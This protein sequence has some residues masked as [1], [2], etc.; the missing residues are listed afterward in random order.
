M[1]VGDNEATACAGDGHIELAGLFLPF[2]I[3]VGV[4]AGIFAVDCIVDDDGVE[5]QSLGLMDGGDEHAL[6]HA[7]RA[8]EV[9]LLHGT[10]VGIM[11][12]ELFG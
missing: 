11:A 10:E 2:L 5:L 12:A 4:D 9:G 8:A 1:A 3:V 6:R 7:G